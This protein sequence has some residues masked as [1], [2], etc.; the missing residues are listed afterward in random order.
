MADFIVLFYHNVNI[1]P[2]NY[3]LVSDCNIE[4]DIHNIIYCVIL[5]FIS[6]QIIAL[7]FRGRIQL[8]VCEIW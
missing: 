5:I 2:T 3:H 8:N 4:Q 6:V 7:Y 1:T